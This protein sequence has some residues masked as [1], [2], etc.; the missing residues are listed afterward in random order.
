[1]A[2]HRRRHAH[3]AD[4]VAAYDLRPGSQHHGR[5]SHQ[6]DDDGHRREDGRP[7]D[8]VHLQRALSRRFEQSERRDGRDSGEEAPPGAGAGGL[9]VSGQRCGRILAHASREE[10]KWRYS[11]FFVYVRSNLS[12]RRAAGRAREGGKMHKRRKRTAAAVGASTHGWPGSDERGDDR[13]L[14]DRRRCGQCGGVRL[15][16]P[17]LL[18]ACSGVSKMEFGLAWA[19]PLEWVGLMEDVQPGDRVVLIKELTIPFRRASCKRF[20]AAKANAPSE[21]AYANARA[22]IERAERWL[23]MLGYSRIAVERDPLLK[24]LSMTRAAATPPECFAALDD[25]EDEA[26]AN[27]S[28]RKKSQHLHT[29]RSSNVDSHNQEPSWLLRG[30]TAPQMID[31]LLESALRANAVNAAVMKRSEKQGASYQTTRINCKTVG[32]AAAAQCVSVAVTIALAERELRARG[33]RRR[34]TA[35]N[36]FDPCELASEPVLQRAHDASRRAC[37]NYARASAPWTTFGNNSSSRS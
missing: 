13:H 31:R 3:V 26:C 4:L 17:Q 12:A 24:V 34:P 21:A 16:Q 19:K 8:P 18:R 6:G 5:L 35:T 15:A 29:V 37:T 7:G 2:L 9:N 30:G 1:M 14:P 27:V 23:R 10:E 32:Q 28:A 36:A 25:D 11:A 22:S 33:T 20:R